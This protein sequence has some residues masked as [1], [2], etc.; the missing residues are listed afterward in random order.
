M[1]RQR[2]RTEEGRGKKLQRKNQELRWGLEKLMKNHKLHSES[3]M[4]FWC[5]TEEQNS[6][7]LEWKV[8]SG[9]IKSGNNKGSQPNPSVCTKIVLSC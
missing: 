1:E 8:F 9:V 3:Q 2:G 6:S 4:V 5:D 7:F